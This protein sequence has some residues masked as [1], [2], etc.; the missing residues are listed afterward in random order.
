LARA[1][2][3]YAKDGGMALKRASDPDMNE[4]DDD[5]SETGNNDSK[6][7]TYLAKSS[8]ARL[9]EFCTED[10]TI[11]FYSNAH[12]WYSSNGA[13]TMLGI[14]YFLPGGSAAG[15]FTINFYTESLNGIQYQRLVISMDRIAQ[16]VH[17]ACSTGE[18]TNIKDAK[19]VSYRKTFTDQCKKRYHTDIMP[20]MVD[21]NLSYPTHFDFHYLQLLD[22]NM[23]PTTL[24]VLSLRMKSLST[25]MVEAKTTIAHTYNIAEQVLKD[26][27]IAQSQARSTTSRE[28]MPPPGTQQMTRQVVNDDAFSAAASQ[29]SMSSQAQIKKLNM[30]IQQLERT[31]ARVQQPRIF[32]PMEQRD[33]STTQMVQPQQYLSPPTAPVGYAAGVPVSP[34]Q[35]ATRANPGLDDTPLQ[36]IGKQ[37][38]TTATD[39]YNLPHEYF[40]DS[41]EH[42]KYNL[43]DTLEQDDDND[44]DL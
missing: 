5:A 32:P 16:T 17:P 18:N 43:G 3:S 34:E 24:L 36:F 44:R 15:D 19:S 7:A 14:D 20:F 29:Y 39:M 28:Q 1:I 31:N 8:E 40:D 23:V 41:D 25:E 27:S 42:D 4:H 35:V 21:T 11:R 9:K 37:P 22:N 10:D 38:R 30:K 33:H 26:R 2:T 12:V 6:L 13:D